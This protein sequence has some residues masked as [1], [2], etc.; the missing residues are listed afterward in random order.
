MGFNR[1]SERLGLAG[2][3]WSGVAPGW[4]NGLQLVP[5]TGWLVPEVVLPEVELGA[6]E[7]GAVWVGR[8]FLGTGLNKPGLS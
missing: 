6:V 3:C 4:G 7:L 1:V 5:G 2:C 8:V